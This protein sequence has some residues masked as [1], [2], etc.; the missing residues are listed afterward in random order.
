MVNNN[1]VM[2]CIGPR[3]FVS[4]VDGAIMPIPVLRSYTQ[5]MRSI[6]D[7]V[8]ESRTAAKSYY[9]S[10]AP[11]QDS[12]Y[13]ARKLQ[14]M[15][16]AV[17]RLAQDDCKSTNY[18]PW[19]VKP[20]EFKN[21]NK[22]YSGDLKFIVGK[23]YLD[24]VSNSL[25]A[26]TINDTHLNNTTIKMRS[27]ITCITEN[28]NE[29]CRV[30]FGELSNSIMPHEN[31]GHK[32]AATMTRQTSQSVLGIKHIDSSSVFDLIN[33]TP[34]LKKF[35]V[36][37]DKGD[38]YILNESYSDKGIKIVI[39]RDE[40]PGLT[41]ILLVDSV[42]NLNPT[43]VSSIKNI[44]IIFNGVS[45]NTPL[46]LSI[47]HNGKNSLITIEFLEYIKL[48]GWT[49]NDS[50]AFVFD[51]DKWNFKL[52]LFRMPNMEYSFS[53]HS[54]EISML[55]ESKMENISER[56]KPLSVY[57]TLSELFDLVNSKINVNIALL[58]IILYSM[59]CRDILNEDYRLGRNVPDPSLGI[60]KNTIANRSLSLAYAFENQTKTILSPKSFFSD[61]RPSSIFDVFI[62]PDE[63]LRSIRNGME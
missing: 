63:V 18:L 57:R 16:M 32:C 49:I 24:E 35:F 48:N 44:G 10:E 42:S 26:I 37:T 11:L 46:S 62:C 40:L 61:K 8:A 19:H 36:P 47:A 52:P 5:G 27:P 21:G 6:Y 14:L 2:Q 45:D 33:F 17:E 59:M 55:I 23:Y 56:L 9:F 31:V 7:M 38:I 53:K 43:R 39:S 15:A 54:K 58:E 51:L 41:D 60:N 22:V 30:C 34:E 20:E 50:N 4:E 3:G 29:V 13:F 12:E 28:P 1:Q 25:K